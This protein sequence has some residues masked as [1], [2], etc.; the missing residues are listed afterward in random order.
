MEINDV[1]TLNENEE[2][3]ILD[4]AELNNETYLYSVLIDEND[5]PTKE[6]AYLK[7]TEEDGEIYVEEVEDEELQKVLTALFTSNFVNEAIGEE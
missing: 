6:Y 3:L 2:Y 1:L 5:M 7:K 4:M